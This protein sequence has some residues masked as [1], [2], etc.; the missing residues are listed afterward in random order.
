MAVDTATKPTVVSGGELAI[1]RMEVASGLKVSLFADETQISHPVAFCAD[2][3]GHF[4]V[5][6]SF[7]FIDPSGAWT[8]IRPHLD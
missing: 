4:Y 2:E 7:R 1:K 3:Q 8:D 6:E 5:S